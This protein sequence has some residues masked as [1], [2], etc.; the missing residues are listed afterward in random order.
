MEKAAN[1]PKIGLLSA[2]AFSVGTM[3]GAGVFVL[4]G[5]AIGFAGPGA[6]LSFTLAGLSVL[7]SALSFSVVTALAPA[8]ASG[9][10]YVRTALGQL[11]GFI[12]SWSFYIGGVIGCAF[13]LNGFGI[14]LNK[15]FVPQVDPLILSL[16]AAIALTLLNFGGASTIAKAETVLVVIKVL[17][18][19]FFI[20]MG[21]QFWN[22]SLFTP[23]LP[24]GLRPV[25]HESGQL[26]VAFLGFS[27]VCSMAGDIKDAPKTIPKAILLSMLIVALIYAGIV[28]TLLAA[29]LPRYTEASIG[30]AAREI[31]GENGLLIISSAA[32]VSILSCANANI[33][34]C[35]E[36]LV[37][38][39]GKGEVPTVIGKMYNGHP[40]FSVLFGAVVYISLMLSGN[41]EK[42]V[43]Y[44]N[45]TTIVM[46]ILVNL[47]AF[48]ALRK[49]LL[50]KGIYPFSM[51]VPVLGLLFSLAQLF[52]M[53]IK[54]IV[55]GLLFIIP[56]S[57]LFF[58]RKRFHR[59]QDHKEIKQ[60]LSE[61]DGPLSRALK[62]KEK[63]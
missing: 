34:G 45:I 38:L 52:M 28:V 9:F 59:G 36:T 61:M 11:L 2:I 53:E 14:Y 25:F 30:T 54:S 7:F 63:V 8:G 48:Y 21:I 32:L 29:H 47:A 3:V 33:L 31:I 51:I 23:F 17:A 1:R 41:S 55:I 5:P 49:K 35:S 57:I 22:R 15:F 42:I 39:A 46:L 16:A 40:V 19:L 58:L 4:S 26:F 62:S 20:I 60:N 24:N 13:I 50:Y 18:L 43:S 37:R 56:G 12:T 10:A 6:L 27:V 44:T